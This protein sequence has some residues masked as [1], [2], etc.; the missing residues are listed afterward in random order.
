RAGR[1]AAGWQSPSGATFRPRA[2]P[3]GDTAGL[4]GDI[5]PMTPRLTADPAMVATATGSG[6]FGTVDF[7]S[8]IGP[9]PEPL[10][11]GSLQGVIN[12]TWNR[13]LQINGDTVTFSRAYV[14]ANPVPEPS[15]F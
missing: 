5:T 2:P 10:A 7:D 14:A 11:V 8:T 12:F 13:N 9:K 3:R 15:G 4:S 1:S 6:T